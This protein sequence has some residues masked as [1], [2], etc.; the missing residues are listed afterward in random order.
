MGQ[1][2]GDVLYN[3]LTGKADEDDFIR[4]DSVA[5]ESNRIIVSFSG[6][7]GSLVEDNSI[8]GPVVGGMPPAYLGFRLTGSSKHSLVGAA[9]TGP[10]EVTLTVNRT[11]DRSLSLILGDSKSLSDGSKNSF[12]GTSLRDSQTEPADNPFGIFQMMN[13]VV[14]KFVPSQT[15]TLDK[16]G[17]ISGTVE[18]TATVL[19]R[20]LVNGTGGDD[21][22]TG[23][24]ASETLL[25]GA[26]NDRLD[27]GAGHDVLTGG[28]GADA[29]V[30]KHFGRSDVISDFAVAEGDAID[31]SALFGSWNVDAASIDHYL[32]LEVVDGNTTRLLADL[33]GQG[34]DFQSVALINHSAET[35]DLGIL[36]SQGNLVV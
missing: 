26:G 7:Q 18:T 30:F 23:S 21:V 35:L 6:L 28:T 32:R 1:E 19:K 13:S 4:I 8:F 31:V 36:L 12:G 33:D 5:V 15:V 34:G 25:G 17:L 22:L 20:L 24:A 3:A 11:V 14:K 29:F 10:D 16:L 9:I 2:T 27:G